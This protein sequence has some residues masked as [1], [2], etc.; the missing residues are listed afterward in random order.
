MN[1]QRGN[2]YGDTTTNFTQLSKKSV[3]TDNMY[4]L[5]LLSYHHRPP[6]FL[7]TFARIFSARCRLACPETLAHHTDSSKLE[8]GL[9]RRLILDAG[10]HIKRAVDSL[11]FCF[12][13]TNVNCTGRLGDVIS[14][15][16]T[17]IA[18]EG[19]YLG[20]C[21]LEPG[22]KLFSVDVR[23]SNPHHKGSSLTESSSIMSDVREWIS[24]RSD[25]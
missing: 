18:A 19:M 13:S 25:N 16:P 14:R 21:L 17:R 6:I 2:A 10:L 12:D 20:S 11:Y 23:A 7:S 15:S 3:R 22:G 24:H 9:C 5:L 1:R 4:R 8:S